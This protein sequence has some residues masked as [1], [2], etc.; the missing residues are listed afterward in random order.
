MQSAPHPSDYRMLSPHRKWV[1]SASLIAFIIVALGVLAGLSS[2]RGGRPW[3]AN[4][5]IRLQTTNGG[6]P[7]PLGGLGAIPLPPSL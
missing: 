3:P 7:L 5:E 1:A 6:S 2:L 4:P